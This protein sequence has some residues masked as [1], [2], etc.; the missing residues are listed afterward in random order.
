MTMIFGV[1]ILYATQS[2]AYGTTP[3]GASTELIQ[4]VDTDSGVDSRWICEPMRRKTERYCMCANSLWLIVADLNMRHST[5]AYYIRLKSR[6]R[7][8][9]LE[10]LK[11]ART[12]LGA[13]ARYCAR[14]KK[15]AKGMKENLA[16][17]SGEVRWLENKLR[18]EYY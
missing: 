4:N 12:N 18:S 16:I 10:L 14:F 3:S 17:V 13:G 1:F 11:E 7:F 15:V 2:E 6:S 5:F 9:V 8:G